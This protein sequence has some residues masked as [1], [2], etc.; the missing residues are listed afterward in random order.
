[1]DPDL[2]QI[3]REQVELEKQSLAILKKLHHDVIYR[4]VFNF[5]KYG[6]MIALTVFGYVQLRPYLDQWLS[7]ISNLQSALPKIK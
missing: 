4:R 1:M 3:L 2:K 6:I 5:L 7:T